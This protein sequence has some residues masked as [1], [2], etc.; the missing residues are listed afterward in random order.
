MDPVKRAPADKELIFMKEEL[1]KAGK[2]NPFLI[3]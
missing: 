3:S 1:R 2:V